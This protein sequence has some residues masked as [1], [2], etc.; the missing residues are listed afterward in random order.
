MQTITELAFFDIADKPI[1]TRQRF[2]WA[3]RLIKAQISLN[4]KRLSLC[5]YNIFQSVPPFWIKP[6]SIGEFIQKRFKIA[7]F[8]RSS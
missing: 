8:C 4:P 1:N 7:E 2:S 5:A 6:V 3:Y